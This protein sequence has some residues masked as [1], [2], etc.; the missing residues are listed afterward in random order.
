MFIFDFFLVKFLLAHY[1][2]MLLLELFL[3]RREAGPKAH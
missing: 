3:F 2:V 1:I